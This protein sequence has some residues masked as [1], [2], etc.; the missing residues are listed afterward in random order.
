[1][2]TGRSAFIA[3]RDW[4][5]VRGRQRIR[6]L[7]STNPTSRLTPLAI[8]ILPHPSMY[9]GDF[10]CQQVKWGHNVI[11]D[12]EGLYSWTEA[13]NLELL[14]D[15]KG[16]VSFIS[17]GGNLGTNPDLAFANAGH[18]N[19]LPD[20]SVLAVT[21]PT[22]SYNVT[23]IPNSCL[24]PSG[25]VLE[26]SQRW[27]ETLLPSHRWICLLCTTSSLPHATSES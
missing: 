2:D 13:N 19:R 23:E 20:R 22:L 21:T 1:M 24:E 17:H 7:T 4:V 5:V 25:K 12:D 6:S 15:T 9:A 3:I 8:P 16:V 26:L 14:H 27:L 11:F 10:N 18:D